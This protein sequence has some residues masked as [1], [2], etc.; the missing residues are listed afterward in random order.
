MNTNSLNLLPA[1]PEIVLLCGLF[2][3]LLIDLW[4]KDGQRRVTHYLSLLVLALAAAAQ[5][6]VWT[7][8]AVS[9]FSD[10]YLSDGLS[11]LAKLT[12]YA[13]LAAAFVYA[14]PYNRVRGIFGG[15]FYTLSLFGLTGMS[16]MAS[17]GHFLVAYIGL[18]LL[19]LSLYAMIALRRDSAR[20]AEAALK[21]F[22]LGALASGLLLY[23]VSMIYGATGSL[24][25]AT[26]LANSYSGLDQ[27][28][29]MKL[30]LIFVVVGIAFKL[31]AVPFH[32]WVPDVYEGA[33]TSVAAIV[34]SAPKMAAAV[35]AARI[36]YGAMD[37]EHADWTQM[38]AV[39]AVA[40]LLVG[41]LAAIMQTNLK[42]MLAYSTV[43]HMGFVLLA[44]LGGSISFSAG[45]YYALTY[46]ATALVGF[47]V[48]MQLSDETADCE[49]IADLAGLNQR[50]A[51]YA[52]LMLL[53]MFSMAGI[54]PL[55][56]F[57]AKFQVIQLLVGKGYL[58]L[59][60]FAVVMSLIGAFYYLRVVR[61]I[62]FDEPQNVRI[63]PGSAV[64]KAVLSANA[65][66]LLL[67]GILP[68]SVMDWCVQA[69]QTAAG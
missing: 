56:G 28:W 7:P 58:W 53:T 49:T 11:Q 64:A 16:M 31:G 57:Y 48:L 41:N 34:G 54:P 8:V 42:R 60:V 52:F 14:A 26:I 2:S 44:F 19:S 38:L 4:L 32:M 9:I 1:L 39:I 61:T 36:L 3:V 23:G 62:Y 13:A 18:E 69:V 10:M 59:A 27:P 30:G 37:N 5:C 50:N 46:V 22:V 35:F 47:G 40:S 20:A 68:Q 12:M 43:S 6:Y 67:W 29:L 65:L 55:V 17:A 33:P 45:L 63:R 24:N 15:E 25:F 51:W 66:L 21:Y